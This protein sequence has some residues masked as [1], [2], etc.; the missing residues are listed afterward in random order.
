MENCTPKHETIAI[1]AEWRA[2]NK[3][4]NW[5]NTLEETTLKKSDIYA[6]VSAMR[7]DGYPKERPGD[8]VMTDK[9]E[10][11]VKL[12]AALAETMDDKMWASDMLAWCDKIESAVAEIRKIARSRISSER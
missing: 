12:V 4:L 2:L 11:H 9:I 8:T 3:V 5:L 6:A 10:K 7:P 1:L